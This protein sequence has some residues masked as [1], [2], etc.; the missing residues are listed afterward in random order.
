MHLGNTSRGAVYD[1]TVSDGTFG[2]CSRC[3]HLR[4]PRTSI[5]WQ[6]YGWVGQ[7]GWS[8]RAGVA[9]SMRAGRKVTH[10]HAFRFSRTF[11]CAYTFLC[12]C[13]FLYAR[14][15]RSFSYVFLV[16]VHVSLLLLVSAVDSVMF[17]A[18]SDSFFLFLASVWLVLPSCLV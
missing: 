9:C 14:A 6:G 8:F 11:S 13:A 10:A 4:R 3:L 12:T 16:A 15:L 1:A 17:R 7:R 2:E 18:R 5:Q